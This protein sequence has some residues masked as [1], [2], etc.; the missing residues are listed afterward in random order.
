MQLSNID[1]QEIFQSVCGIHHK[2]SKNSLNPFLD[3]NGVLRV[4]GRLEHAHLHPH[5]KHPAILL[6]KNHIS[7]LLIEHFHQKVHH[8]E[9]GMTMNELRSNGIWLLRCSHAVSS[10]IYKC[11][12]CRKFRRN[13]EV[14]RMADLPRERVETS[15]PFC[16]VWP[17]LR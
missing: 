14:Q 1:L 17:I 13:A 8:Q 4:G 2:G 11:V 12:K 3:E 10:Y 5:I 9:R 7:K 15:P 6:S 16:L